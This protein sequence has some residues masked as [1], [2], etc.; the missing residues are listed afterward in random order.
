VG[1][2]DQPEVVAV[3]VVPSTPVPERETVPPLGGD[4]GA[5]TVAVFEKAWFDPP[6]FDAVTRQRIGLKYPKLKK[7]EGGE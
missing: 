5:A 4:R 1:E 7:L 6:A 2:F 3:K